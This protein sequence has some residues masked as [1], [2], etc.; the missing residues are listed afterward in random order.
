MFLQTHRVVTILDA[1]HPFA[2]EIS[3]LAIAAASEFRIP[4]LRYERETILDP[5]QSCHDLCYFE[6]FPSLLGSNRLLDQRVFLAIG[7]RPLHLFQ[8]WQAKATLFTRI[9]PSIPALEA[10]IAA[11]FSSDRIIAMRP[12]I[13]AQ[14]ERA[15]W[16]QWQISM[17][18]TKASGIAGGEDIKR[19]IAADLGIQLVM[20]TR[21]ELNYPRQTS[22][23]SA[24]LEI[25][26]QAVLPANGADLR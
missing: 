24:A 16:Q 18:V 26:R 21:P 2:V 10:A 8:A 14:M 15:L 23:V 11:G 4:Y 9:L 13:S 7:Y 3:Q 19:Q 20:I 25:C 12:P 22:N 1:S 17:V 6:S 5:P